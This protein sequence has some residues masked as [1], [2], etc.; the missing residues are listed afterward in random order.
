MRRL[1]KAVLFV[2]KVPKMQNILNVKDIRF[3]KGRYLNNPDKNPINDT[4]DEPLL[5]FALCMSTSL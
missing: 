1:D 4:Q 5:E 2:K 3:L